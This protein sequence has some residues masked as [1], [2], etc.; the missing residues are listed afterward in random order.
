[1]NSS[2]S[3]Q[4]AIWN[5][6]NA[7]TMVRFGLSVLVFA[8]LS[9]Q[10]PWA[11][12][13]VFTVA[14][15][16]DWMDGYWARKYNQVTQFGRILDPFVDKIII[17][18]TFIYL[19]AESASGIVPWMA[20]VVVGREMLVTVLRS[21]IE[22]HGGD[23]SANW[24]GKW[25]MVLQCV[26]AGASMVVLGWRPELQSEWATST[27]YGAAGIEPRWLALVLLT[28]VWGAILLTLYSGWVYI[29]DAARLIRGGLAG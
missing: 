10:L 11:A 28:C 19:A 27:W 20:V 29:L 22:Q 18:G 26:A 9:L 12:L 17:C 25:K 16:T 8:L 7:I 15:S 1:M 14:A 4:T 3:S 2:V 24:T 23:F 6:P 13:V 5:V 21:F